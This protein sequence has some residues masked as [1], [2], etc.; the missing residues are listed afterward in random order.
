MPNPALA[1]WGLKTWP[2]RFCLTAN[3]RTSYVLRVW[4]Q[5]AVATKAITLNPT[6]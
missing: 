6:P 4:L 3:P 1:T 2:A 5:Q